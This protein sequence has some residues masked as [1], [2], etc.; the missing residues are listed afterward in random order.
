MTQLPQIGTTITNCPIC[1]DRLA[2]PVIYNGEA[3]ALLCEACQAPG[4]PD[5]INGTDSV[6]VLF[7][8]KPSPVGLPPQ[9][10]IIAILEEYLQLAVTG[11]ITGLIMIGFSDPGLAKASITGKVPMPNGVTAL[12]QM[13]FGI[14]ARDYAANI[15]LHSQPT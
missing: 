6:H 3:S 1:Q 9:P 14:M 12:E 13:K 4:P 10:D 15:Q 2:S 5:G 11:K 8:N 7:P